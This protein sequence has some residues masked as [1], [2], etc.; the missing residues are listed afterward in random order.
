MQA[1]WQIRVDLVGGDAGTRPLAGGDKDLG[2]GATRAAHA[3]D[4]VGRLHMRLRPADSDAGL[5][6]GRSLD[7]GRDRPALGSSCRAGPGPRAACGSA[8]TCDRSRTSRGRSNAARWEQQEPYAPP[9]PTGPV[10][11]ASLR[12]PRRCRPPAAGSPSRAS[13]RT[14]RGCRAR[15]PFGSGLRGR[16]S[17][18]CAAHAATSAPKPAVS[19][20][21]CTT[22]SRWVRRT[23][24][25]TSSRSQGEIVRRSITSTSHPRSSCRP[26]RGLQRLLDR[27]APRHDRDVVGRVGGCRPRPNGST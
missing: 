4:D 2:G 6:V 7:L 10:R 23:L 18:S 1:A 14:R 21:S 8:C 5:G 27:R 15:P 26:L 9:Q 25:P 3:L 11:G 24:S 22:T 17:T 16:S 20:S 13:A 19:T 12:A